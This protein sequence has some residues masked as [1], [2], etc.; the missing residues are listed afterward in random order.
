[1]RILTK[2]SDDGEEAEDGKLKG[3]LCWSA[4]MRGPVDVVNMLIGDIGL[5]SFAMGVAPLPWE[6]YHFNILLVA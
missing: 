4:V 5:L 3:C 1:M 6:L 2:G